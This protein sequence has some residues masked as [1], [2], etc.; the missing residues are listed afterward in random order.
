[1]AKVGAYYDRARILYL[2]GNSLKKI[3]RVLPVGERT[4]WRWKR[5]GDWDGRGCEPTISNRRTLEI[6]R[7]HLDRKIQE[8]DKGMT[9]SDVVEIAKISASIDRMER[10]A[11]DM[12]GSAVEIMDLYAR[13]LKST[14]SR[15]EVEKQARIIH[16]FIQYL[17]ETL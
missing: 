12:R 11:G 2:E 14:F 1:M 9:S 10:A 5:K 6:L 15:K 8:L 3:S 16:A 4:L 7:E 17:E 13:F